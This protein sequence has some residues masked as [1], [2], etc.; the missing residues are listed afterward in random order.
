[1]SAMTLRTRL[2]SYV[3]SLWGSYLRRVVLGSVGLFG[4]LPAV[5][6]FLGGTFTLGVYIGTGGAVLWYTVE[7]YYLSPYL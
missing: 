5:V 7:T 1:M 4:L 6:V 2:R 3:K